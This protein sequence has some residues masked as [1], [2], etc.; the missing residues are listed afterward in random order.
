MAKDLYE[1]LGVARGASA[2][3]IKKSYRDLA[4]RFHPDRN[5]GNKQAEERF[6]EVSVA[7]EVLSDPDKRARYD[8]FGLDG[9]AAGFDPQRARGVRRGRGRGAPVDFGGDVQEFDLGEMFA[10]LFG[11][12]GG[13]GVAFHSMRG[14][15]YETT[16]EVDLPDALRGGEVTLQMESGRITVRIPPHVEDGAVLRVR[17]K[18][19]KAPRGGTSGD[20]LVRVRVRPHPTLRREDGVAVLEVPVTV[21]E[22]VAGAKIDVP[23]L[24]G[25]VSLKV[26]PHS[27]TGT[28]LRLRGKGG[29][30][31]DLIVELQVE[32]PTGGGK[33][34]EEAARALDA[35]YVGSVRSKLRL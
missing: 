23:T 13:P 25:P 30:G 28:R 9:L 33:A 34:A 12:G 14:A 11:G 10:D 7:Y 22:A 5:P 29:G 16:V 21:S 31:K 24:T 15:D 19:G 4:K 35:H 2:E 17:G 8:E 32:V 18:G 26:P 27:Q 6:K 20:L 3:E 1:I